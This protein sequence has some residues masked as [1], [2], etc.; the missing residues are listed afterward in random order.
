LV[1]L[2][3]DDF[4]GHSWPAM[5]CLK[6][7]S[8]RRTCLT[9]RSGATRRGMLWCSSF[10]EVGEVHFFP[11][12]GSHI[13]P[14]FSCFFCRSFVEHWPRLAVGISGIRSQQRF[15]GNLFTRESVCT[16]S[17]RSWY[18][19]AS[20]QSDLSWDGSGCPGFCRA[21]IPVEEFSE[22]PLLL[23]GHVLLGMIF[24]FLWLR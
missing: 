20:Q 3:S 13:A 23:L 16:L 11:F 1:V 24:H 12:P 6:C 8:L 7:M 4:D 17:V 19:M 14:S 9:C 21:L 15:L 5:A 2:D 10:P 18:E 22:M